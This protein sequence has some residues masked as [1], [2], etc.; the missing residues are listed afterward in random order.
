VDDDAVTLCCLLWARPG[1]AD[2]LSRYEDQVL[3]F[4]PDHDGVVL[5]RARSQGEDGS[6]DEVQMLRF[7]SSAALESF[8]QDPRRT[9]LGDERDRVIAR[10]EVF[11]VEL[12]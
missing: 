3:A 12:I 8:V 4:L 1:L 7:A 11:P 9:T 10:T 5:Q 2:D 6:P